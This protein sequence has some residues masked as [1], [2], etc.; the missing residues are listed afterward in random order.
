MDNFFPHYDSAWKVRNE[1]KLITEIQLIANYSSTTF[2][3]A[4]RIPKKK[5]ELYFCFW[6]FHY[7][8]S[9]SVNGTIST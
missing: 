6:Y 4:T 7:N 9:A 5:K 1:R 3:F 8:Y 2:V